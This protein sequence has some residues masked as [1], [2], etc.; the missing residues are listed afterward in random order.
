MSLCRIWIVRY[1]RFCPRTSRSS[2]FTIVPAPWCGYTTLSPTLYKRIPF[3]ATEIAMKNGR[4]WVAAGTEASLYHKIAGKR[5]ICGA[6]A[7]VAAPSPKSPAQS[8]LPLPKLRDG[9]RV[10]VRVDEP[11]D[12]GAAGRAPDTVNV[13]LH[14]RVARGL[15]AAGPEAVD[16]GRHVLDDPAEDGV[17]LRIDALD[18][19]DPQRRAGEVEDERERLVRDE[20]EAQDVAIEVERA[21]GIGRGDERHGPRVTQHYSWR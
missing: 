14:P 3:L 1:S 17:G 12:P 5:P 8:G 11:R 20:L 2:F 9:E 15:D 19:R 21:R 10:A 16:G 7:R 4:Q 18:L 13:L 6:R